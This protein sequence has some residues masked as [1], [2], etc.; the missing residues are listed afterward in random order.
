MLWQY[1]RC[2]LCTWWV[3]ISQRHPRWF[4]LDPLL[5]VRLQQHCLRQLRHT[6]LSPVSAR[7][8]VSRLHTLYNLRI[9][10]LVEHTPVTPL[11][12]HS[13]LFLILDI[14]VQWAW[15]HYVQYNT[16]QYSTVQ[17]CRCTNTLILLTCD[18]HVHALR[19]NVRS[20]VQAD[21]MQITN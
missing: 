8:S 21:C 19:W 13:H 18:M 11:S 7:Y 9:T 12:L 2:F 3:W 16:V 6:V 1:Q 20:H 15:K 5:S 4:L 14:H 17:C 10:R